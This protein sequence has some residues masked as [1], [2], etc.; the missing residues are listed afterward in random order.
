MARPIISK[1]P[2]F[3]R[4]ADTTAY[5]AGDLVA[6]STTAASV[7]PMRFNLPLYATIRRARL[8]KSA[9]STTNASMRLHLYNELPTP[10][11][12]DNGAWSTDVAGYLGFIDLTYDDAFTD[13]A[14]AFGIPIHTTEEAITFGITARK[15]VDGCIYGLIEALAAYTPAS[16]E[17]FQVMLFGDA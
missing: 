9:T 15:S 14:V 11:N 2:T 5:A 4:P 16:A 6:N 7:T 12:G 17:T 10:A 13:D 3:T 8:V 1:A